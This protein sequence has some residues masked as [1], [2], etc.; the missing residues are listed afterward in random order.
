MLYFGYRQ[1]GEGRGQDFCPKANSPPTHNQWT[2]ALTGRVRELNAETAQSALPV[3][4]KLVI[5]GMTRVILIVSSTVNF[6]FWGQFV[7]ISLRP[8]LRIVA[9]DVMVT[10]WS[11]CK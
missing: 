2:S 9:A 5:G 4:L 6:Q 1:P 11:S 10:D 3:T 8:V 7:P